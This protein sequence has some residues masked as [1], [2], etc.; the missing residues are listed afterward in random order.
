MGDAT[1]HPPV[2]PLLVAFGTDPA[3]LAWAREEAVAEWG[4]VALESSLFDF[5]ETDYYATS[6]GA[7]LKLQIVAFE[8]LMSPDELAARKLQTN[9]WEQTYAERG[10]S[11]AARPVNLDPGYLTPAKFVLASTKD[12]S[13]RLYLGRGIF[14]EVTLYYSRGEWTSRPWTYPNYRRADYHQFLTACRQRLRQHESKG[15]S[16]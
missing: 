15:P 1:L 6:M 16:K 9:A 7:D 4:A 3:A 5:A 14:G 12:H 8:R 10:E 11:V 2:M 13:H